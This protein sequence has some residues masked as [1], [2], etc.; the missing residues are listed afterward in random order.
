M[1]GN[2]FIYILPG[3]TRDHREQTACWDSGAES[4]AIGNVLMTRQFRD[5]KR[6]IT[7]LL[8]STATPYKNAEALYVWGVG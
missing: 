3:G 8:S 5:I 1:A 7:S 2:R 6:T 4:P